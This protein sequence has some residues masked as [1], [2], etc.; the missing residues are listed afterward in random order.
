MYWICQVDLNTED[1]FLYENM[2]YGWTTRNWLK[3]PIFHWII[4]VGLCVQ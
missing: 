2:T 3:V 4:Y 1:L